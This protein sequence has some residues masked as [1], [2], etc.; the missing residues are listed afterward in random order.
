[1][2][3]LSAVITTF[4][5]ADFIEDCIKS[6][7]FADEIVVVDN[8]SKDKTLEIAKKYHVKIY[9]HQNNP[10]CLN[11]SKNYGFGQ[12]KGDWILSLDSDE[13]VD[14]ELAAEIKAI[15]SQAE[16]TADGFLIPRKNI[17][18][19]KWIRHGL[20]YPDHQLRLFKKGAGKFPG[21][22]NHELLVV[23]GPV[24][25]VKNHITHLN[26]QSV[27]QYIQ[28]IDKQYSN[29]EVDT[30]LAKGNQIHAYDALRFPFQDFLTNYFAR[31]AYKDGLHG[32]VLSLLQ[33]FYMFIVFCK[34][35]ERQQFK[36]MAIGLPE[37]QSEL[38][39]FS[40]QLKYWF[41]HSQHAHA[42]LPEKILLKI[43]S[44]F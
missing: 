5:S 3:H 24:K 23:N 1:M 31:E 33:A 13:R 38:R 40:K 11:E 32:L 9:P 34:I 12:A 6:V 21:H 16:I 10:D 20:W 22:H 25:Y 19:G 30:F 36:P 39:H 18:F 4:N 41:I 29:N 14:P 28:K 35:W 15:I 37:T 7:A 44:V 43:K 2:N 27:S 26:Y 17:I 42:K 8:G